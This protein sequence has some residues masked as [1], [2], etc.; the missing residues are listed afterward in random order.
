MTREEL[1][2]LRD[3][4]GTVLTRR[5]EF[6]QT[7]GRY[8]EDGRYV[9]ERRSSGSDGHRKVFESFEACED[10]FDDLPRTFSASDLEYPGVTGSRRHMLVWHFCEHPVFPCSLVAR[11]PL[12]GRKITVTDETGVASRADDG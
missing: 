8:R 10:C 12:S 6:T 5:A 9:V 2:S 11:Q 4:I 3:R 7:T 1:A